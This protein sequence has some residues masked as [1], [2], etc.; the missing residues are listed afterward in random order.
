M[1]QYHAIIVGAGL[2]GSAAALSLARR[3]YNVLILEKARVPGHRNMTGGIISTRY[4]RGYGL[5]DL[6]PDLSKTPLER[7]ITRQ[8]VHVV[9]KPDRNGAYRMISMSGSSPFM[10]TGLI[11]NPDT[12]H[13]FSV[14]RGKLDR[15]LASRAVEE[16]AM[17]ATEVT[18]EGL[19]RDNGRVTGVR[20]SNEELLADAVIDASGVTS[21]LPVEIGLRPSLGPE[22]YYLGVKH[23]YSLAPGLIEERFRLNKGEGAAHFYLGHFMKRVHGGAFLYTNRDTVSSGVVFKLLSYIK[24]CVDDLDVGKALDILEEFETHPSIAGYLEGAARVEY[25]GHLVPRGPRCLLTRPFH[26]GFLVAG[27]ALGSFVKLGP[28][29]DGMRRAIATG[30]MAAEAVDIAETRGDFSSRSLS[31]YR[32]LLDPIY[33]DMRRSRLDS[34][35]FENRFAYE[36]M[37]SVLL[38]TP[39]MSKRHRG[40]SRVPKRAPRNAIQLVQE[41]TG[42]LLYDED[43]QHSHIHVD[44]ERCS[45]SASKV[46]VPSCPFN[47]YTLV[48]EKGVFTSYRDLYR[49]N[50]ATLA[51]QRGRNADRLSKDAEKI[52][53]DDITRAK[54]RFDHVAYVGCGTCGVL[55]PAEAVR[56]G[57]ERDGHGV[58]YSYG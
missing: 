46:W 4:L 26:H 28:M 54:V 57:H 23:V 27:D 50:L 22:A 41:R 34:L 2:A 14:L 53:R 43:K 6:V 52:T 29:L 47:C 48:L 15:W 40:L 32:D 19:L 18:V 25:S 5:E 39:V 35:L 10:R 44:L 7:R 33:R 21:S 42:L 31:T 49:L 51:A 12:G 38:S 9:S 1:G 3:G 55:G 37:P 24:R 11:P 45:R 17:L 56:F 36:F 30:I 16:G 20:T 13:D 8:S 58:R